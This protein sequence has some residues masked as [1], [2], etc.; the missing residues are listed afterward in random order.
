MT[1]SMKGRNNGAKSY[2][3]VA[4]IRDCNIGWCLGQQVV[5]LVMYIMYKVIQ[6]CSFLTYVSYQHVTV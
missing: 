5:D 3:M 4:G 2:R 1:K 6:A